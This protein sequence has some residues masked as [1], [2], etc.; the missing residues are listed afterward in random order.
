MI[1]GRILYVEDDVNLAFVTKDNL[2][3][4]GYL[5]H[6]CTS[7]KEALEA[8]QSQLPDI[9]ILD[10][11]LPD[12]DGFALAQ[13]IRKLNAKVPIIFLT[14]KSQKEDKI[15]GLR[16][17]AD[18]YITK[19]FSIEELHLKIQ[20]FLRR[21]NA[22]FPKEEKVFKIGEYLF[23][24]DNLTLH[25]KGK[26]QQLT[27]REA[28]LLGIFCKNKGKLLKREEILQQIWGTDDYFAG[29]SLDV[30]I[31]RLRKYLKEDP[32]ITIENFHGVGFKL[33]APLEK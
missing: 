17:G 14:S 30:F 33:V 18:D 6:H 11:M 19:P 29:R 2:E 1:T 28:D 8:F 27:R 25:H 22:I 9:C 21:S 16:L 10:I 32:R 15:N 7:G 20:V 12:L 13:E 5:V 31:S 3:L 4:Q 23:D 24:A 26:A